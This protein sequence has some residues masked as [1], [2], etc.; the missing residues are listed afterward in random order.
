MDKFKSSP[1]Y[2]SCCH[3]YQRHG[4]TRKVKAL[5]KSFG[6]ILWKPFD[7]C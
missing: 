6:H 1:F 4:A 7:T 2:D 5:P 3:K